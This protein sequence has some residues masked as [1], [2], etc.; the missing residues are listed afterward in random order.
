MPNSFLKRHL[1]GP[2]GI[3][4]LLPIAFPMFLS[5]MFD[6][7]MMFVDRLYLSHV[8]VV[9]QAATMSGGVT[10]WML[11]SFFVGVVGY[12][13]ALIAQYYGAN[14][15]PHCV[16]M[17]RQ[18]FL[19]ALI[20]YPLSLGA[21]WLLLKANV[22][23]LHSETEIALETKY[24]WY[25]GFGSLLSLLRFTFASFFTGIGKTRVILLA[26][27]VALAV[28]VVAN[29]VLI[30]G[31]WGCP[32]LELDGAA[33][34]TLL[35]SLSMVSVLAFQFFRRKREPQF[36]E[37]R[38]PSWMGRSSENSSDTDCPRGWKISSAHSASSSS[39]P[40]STPTGTTWPPPPP[41]SS[42][43]MASPSTPSWESR[44]ASPPWSPRPW[45]RTTPPWPPA[46]RTPASRWPSSMPDA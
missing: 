6:M 21:H 33:M 37:A 11:T 30:F 20:S 22:F 16:R 25:M 35:A 28:N 36:Q 8:G 23:S 19:L 45:A 46:P 7:L 34:G 42:T 27:T 10:S 17:V 40:V 39:S 14:Q 26:N 1:Q 38:H 44:S 2:G 24:Y 32:A 18:A 3:L 13:S 43:G 12:S 5:S 4:E 41:S 15:K 29:W 9:H 31:H